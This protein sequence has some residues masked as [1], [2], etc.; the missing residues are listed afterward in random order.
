[1]SIKYKKE[2]RE[3]KIQKRVTSL[4]LAFIMVLSVFAATPFTAGAVVVSTSGWDG[5]TELKPEGT[6]TAEDPYI[7][8]SAANLKWMGNVAQIGG[9][10]GQDNKANG[11]EGKYFLQV[12][13]IDLNGKVMPSIGSYHVNG[14]KTNP[15]KYQVFGGVYDG[16]GYKIYNGFVGNSNPDH[17]ANGNWGDGLFGYIMG[18]TIK[19]VVL[20]NIGFADRQV[21]YG[22]LLVGAA[23]TNPDGNQADYNIIEN[24]VIEK[25][26]DLSCASSAM[27]DSSMIAG[28]IGGAYSTTIKNCINYAS[29]TVN[30]SNGKGNAGGIFGILNDSCKV[31]YCANYGDLTVG[32]K[33]CAGIGVMMYGNSTAEYCVNYG[34][35]A[36]AGWIAGAFGYTYGSAQITGCINNGNINGTGNRTGGVICGVE[37][38]SKVSNCINT[39]VVTCTSNKYSLGGIASYTS[40]GVIVENCLNSGN[41][42]SEGSTYVGG[43]IGRCTGSSAPTIKNNLNTGDVTTSGTGYVAGI[44]ASYEVGVAT[45]FDGNITTGVIS[46]ANENCVS[47]IA[48]YATGYAHTFTNSVIS[49]T[50]RST[51]TNSALVGIVGYLNNATPNF[52]N[53]VVN[54]EFVNA[55]TGIK[56]NAA[57]YLTNNQS[58]GGTVSGNKVSDTYTKM[59]ID[60][61]GGNVSAAS[62][63][64]LDATSADYDADIANTVNTR[65]ETLKASIESGLDADAIIT[66][67]K[68]EIAKGA[69]SE[70][71]NIYA[72]TKSVG[73]NSYSV[74]FIAEIKGSEWTSAGFNACISYKN[75]DETVLSNK[76]NI[77]VN[78]CY[79]KVY[80]TVEGVTTP[81]EPTEGYYF[82]VFVVDNIPMTNGDITFTLTPYVIDNS[83][84]IYG[85][86]QSATF[87]SA[88]V[89]LN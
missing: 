81:F 8:S 26:C 68:A 86:T 12:C 9:Y 70:I 40:A 44:V 88:G 71:T 38:T 22:G 51:A 85:H 6:G 16:Q 78:A 17:A 65:V 74:R 2:K 69:R 58:V 47:G 27:N 32:G 49:G 41:I 89:P 54:A 67:I 46:S 37:N 57:L 30:N 29:G 5:K 56:L 19:N 3:M 80:Q 45:T 77:S 48:G 87:S 62:K 60:R 66:A 75:G 10:P 20:D 35:M 64:I 33:S 42:S 1:M 7:I 82:I 14:G 34:N 23:A 72:Q 50:I 21:Y 76:K 83:Q 52:T 55:G 61:A 28:I 63:Y 24:C 15:T 39:G 11:L 36:G 53:N 31:L 79:E 43:I 84:T 59:V 18:A 13:D 4:L 25:S 73:E